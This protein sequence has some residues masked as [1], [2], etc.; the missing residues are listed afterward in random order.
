[1]PSFSHE[2]GLWIVFAVIV[3]SMLALDLG[4]L[5]RRAHAVGLREAAAW[6]A[7]WV[8]LAL[9]FAAGIWIWES[10]E[11]GLLFTT[12]YV[13]EESLS[14]D[15]I[16]VFVLVFAS[17]RVPPPYQHRV[18]FWGVLG[19]VLMRAAF[20]AAGIALL[21]ALSWVVYV[22][23]AFLLLTSLRMLRPEKEDV[24]LERHVVIRALRNL[25]PVSSEYHGQRF[26]FVE[27][28]IRFATPLLL[29]LVMIEVSDL[30]FAVDS[31]PAVLAVSRD[32]FIVYTSNIF[33]I[34]GLR[35]LYF[36]IAHAV[37]RLR[38][39]RFGLAAILAFVGVKMLLNGVWHPP[40]V[41][42]L[43]AILTVLAVTAAVS[44]AATAHESRGRGA[45]VAVPPADPGP[46]G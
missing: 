34:M 10:G 19:A 2:T 39:L 36:L 5:H 17:F 9:G 45:T 35:S 21:N 12:G 1:M 11:R 44:L 13:I 3:S 38:Y 28:G 15:N 23:G 16:F 30:I 27:G 25:F 8:G 4:V 37:Q 18:L 32:P 7:V 46:S 26:T 24:E 40:A 6:T 14:I 42:S 20:V 31:V 22:F 33:A 29:T 43:G 41:L